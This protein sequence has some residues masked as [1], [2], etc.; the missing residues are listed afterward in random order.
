MRLPMFL[1][2]W[3]PSPLSLRVTS[4]GRSPP[5]RGPRAPSPRPRP[6]LG[7]S[8]CRPQSTFPEVWP[9]SRRGPG[10]PQGLGVSP[11][12]VCLETVSITEIGGHQAG[13]ESQ[14]PGIRVSGLRLHL[15]DLGKAGGMRG[16]IRTVW[17]L[18]APCF[19]GRGK[20]VNIGSWEPRGHVVAL[21]SSRPSG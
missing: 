17:D 3:G 15:S 4:G 20:L 18:G 6:T 8:T 10:R 11:A 7:L 13:Q 19:L 21:V 14:S 16:S 1:A 5:A 9:G 2:G 12:G